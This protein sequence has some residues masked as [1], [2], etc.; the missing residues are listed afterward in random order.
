MVQCVKEYG[1]GF[2]YFRKGDFSLKDEPVK[3]CPKGHDSE[4]LDLADEIMK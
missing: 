2:T 1:D 3:V 4:V